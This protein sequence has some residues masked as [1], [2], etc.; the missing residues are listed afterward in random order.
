MSSGWL[1]ALAGLSIAL[2]L[3]VPG[4]LAEPTLDA[5]LDTLRQLRIE[6]T[7]TVPPTEA[8]TWRAALDADA[9]GAVSAQEVAAFVSVLE[10]L[11]DGPEVGTLE[12]YNLT[13]AA[14]NASGASG[15]T[16]DGRANLSAFALERAPAFRVAAR[17]DSVNG[18]LERVALTFTNLWGPVGA[19]EGLEVRQLVTISWGAPSGAQAIHRIEVEAPP[20]LAF[21]M[22]VAGGFEIVGFESLVPAT[23]AADHSQV[24]GVTIEYPAVVL[25]R[26]REVGNAA[27][28][29]V[30]LAILAPSVGV[31]YVTLKS[32][33][34]LKVALKPLP[35]EPR[36]R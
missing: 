1:R 6:L 17:L 36:Y 18:T 25:V 22:R 27:L 35:A 24:N 29:L 8:P 34:R 20:R 4:A 3:F 26:A 10:Q 23:L 15:A 32:A 5:R 13:W 16:L 28:V 2:A 31:A 30:I 9:S 19:A 12:A 14:E 11:A 7:G 33:R 21:Q